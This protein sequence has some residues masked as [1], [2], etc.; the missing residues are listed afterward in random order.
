VETDPSD[1]Q[2]AND[3]S[4]E[5]SD[6]ENGKDGDKEIA[7]MQPNSST[8]NFNSLVVHFSLRAVDINTGVH[9]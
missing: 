1:V 7:A 8:V 6:A 2:E 5:T 9:T 3:D 4:Q